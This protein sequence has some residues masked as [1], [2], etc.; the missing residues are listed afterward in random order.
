[1]K[2]LREQIAARCVHF[3]GTVNPACKAGVVYIDLA[4]GDKPG[5]GC[6]I[7]LHQGRLVDAKGG[8][9]RRDRPV[10]RG[11]VADSGTG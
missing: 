3:N 8:R 5:W 4:G 11:K 2:T 10:L 1:M 6:R 7:P 9:V